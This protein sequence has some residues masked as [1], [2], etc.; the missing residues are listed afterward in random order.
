MEDDRI[1]T[2]FWQRDETAIEAT[3]QKYG[4]YC[5]TIADNILGSPEDTE[6][7]V[8]DT[9][10]RAWNAIPP[11]HPARL[12]L[13]L[14]KIVRNLALDRYKRYTA[15]KRGGGNMEAV[16]EE[17]AE[18]VA[19][20]A[21]VESELQGRALRQCLEDFLTAQS[22]RDRR[23]FLRRYFHAESVKEIAASYD[24]RESHVSVILT[25][26]R[27]KLRAHLEKEGWMV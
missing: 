20:T 7:C 9:W 12:K 25:R 23:I 17:L 18:C 26:L 5:R 27:Q 19:G 14:A 22:A 8:N 21:D 4:A 6:E 24:L 2:L 1:I 13:F 16:L 11:H 3:N 10:L 15:E